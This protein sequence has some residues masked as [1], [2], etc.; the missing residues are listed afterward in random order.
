MIKMTISTQCDKCKAVITVRVFNVYHK[1]DGFCSSE[2]N[3]LKKDGWMF[4][5]RD[6][7]HGLESVTCPKCQQPDSDLADEHNLD[8]QSLEWG[9]P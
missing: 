7:G 9:Q 4:K 2:I 6:N 1:G 5:Y 8:P 3:Q